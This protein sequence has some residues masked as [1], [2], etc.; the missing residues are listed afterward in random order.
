MI[1]NN[2]PGLRAGWLFRTALFL[3]LLIAVDFT[4]VST[5]PLWPRGR[6]DKHLKEASALL[7]KEGLYYMPFGRMPTMDNYSDAFTLNIVGTLDPDSPVRSA[8]RMDMAYVPED[9]A[10]P[11]RDL[12]N[13]VEGKATAKQSY[14]RYW[15]GSTVILRPLLAVMDFPDVRKLSFFCLMTL[16]SVA[17]ILLTRRVDGVTALGFAV[18]M[19]LGNFPLLAFCMT[20]IA[21]LA[22][23]LALMC[24]IL[25]WN[26]RDEEKLIRLFLLAGSSTAFLDLLTAPVVTFMLPLLTLL[27]PDLERSPRWDWRRVK[28][29]LLLG[30]V[31]SAGYLLTW[32]AKWVLADIVLGEGT[33]RDAVN[34]VLLRTGSTEGMTF[35]DRI[36]A[37]VKNIYAILPFSVMSTGGKG[38]SGIISALVYQIRDAENFTWFDKLT[39]MIKDVSPLLPSSIF[40]GLIVTVL[41]LAIYLVIVLSLAMDGRK[42][43]PIGA[44]GYFSLALLFLVPYFW[45]FIA[46]NHAGHY[47]CMFRNQ[48]PSVWLFLILPHIMKKRRTQGE[49]EILAEVEEKERA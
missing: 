46:A 8:M 12:E 27:L 44:L 10:D 42:R 36:L 7:N 21:D 32:A 49:I 15:H 1:E 29:I 47:F 4:L 25:R 5:A 30:I 35:F 48:I 26:I 33:V 23:A 37:I 34:E 40:W 31:W 38:M 22:I 18:T 20:Y 45:Y 13:F 39:L 41:V 6:L 16:F 24:V 43:K 11:L 28:S 9:A 19:T 17:I 3:C 14:A 2:M